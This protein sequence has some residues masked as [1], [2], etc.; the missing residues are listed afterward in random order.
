MHASAR[1]FREC[2]RIG[3]TA[4][5]HCCLRAGTYFALKAMSRRAEMIGD[6]ELGMADIKGK[7]HENARLLGG[8]TRRTARTGG[9]MT[10]T[11][12]QTSAI[13]LT[14]CPRRIS[15]R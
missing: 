2:L 14:L 15:K 10:D 5:A 8:A 12:C 6:S 11:A 3:A 13:L 9:C 4:A 7:M 1:V